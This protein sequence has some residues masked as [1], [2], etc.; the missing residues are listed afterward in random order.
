MEKP[1]IGIVSG[2][3]EN[4]KYI[5][6]GRA[7]AEAVL[8]SGGTPIYLPVIPDKQL[9]HHY[10]DLCQGFI[11]TGGPD[12]DP[13]RY[14]EEQKNFCGSVQPDRPLDGLHGGASD[15]QHVF[16]AFIIFPYEQCGNRLTITG[17]QCNGKKVSHHGW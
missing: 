8:A 10:I 6:T 17:G 16:A 11:F 1:I 14:G 7:H 9:I 5:S 15:L 12:I 4:R 2:L 3:S 13:I